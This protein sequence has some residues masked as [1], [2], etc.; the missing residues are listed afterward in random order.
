[1]PVPSQIG[2]FNGHDHVVAGT[3]GDL[4]VAV[5]AEVTLVRLVRLQ[6]FDVYL[7]VSFG[8][9]HQPRIAQRTSSAAI[10]SPAPTYR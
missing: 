3:D 2:R 5:R 9:L 10:R 1:M 7:A 8:V 4:A 6:E